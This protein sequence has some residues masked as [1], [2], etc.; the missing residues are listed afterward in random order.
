M[1]IFV[2]CKE[3][4]GKQFKCTDPDFEGCVGTIVNAWTE[5]EDDWAIIYLS[6]EGDNFRGV[7]NLAEG[8]VL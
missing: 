2:M 8:D 7:F 5:T 3:Y 4:I 1:E 6:V